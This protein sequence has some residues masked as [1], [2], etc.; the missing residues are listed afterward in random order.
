MNWLVDVYL[1]EFLCLRFSMNVIVIL[2]LLYLQFLVSLFT[3]LASEK[4]YSTLAVNLENPSLYLVTKELEK[5]Y[6]CK[7]FCVLMNSIQYSIRRVPTSANSHQQNFHISVSCH[8]AGT[9]IGFKS[10]RGGV[11]HTPSPTFGPE[12]EFFWCEFAVVG[13]LRVNKWKKTSQLIFKNINK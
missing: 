8:A 2:Y 6:S 11:P 4:F 7:D 12:A 13:T 3:L 1:I 10:G 5:I 9:A